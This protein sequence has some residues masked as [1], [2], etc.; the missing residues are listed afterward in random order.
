MIELI[1]GP[2]GNPSS[3][4]QFGR[5]SKTIVEEAR[6]DI[7]KNLGCSGKEI[8]FTSGGTEADNFALNMPI[9]QLGIKRI[10]TSP[11]EHHA[12]LHTAEAVAK[13][14]GVKL[15]LVNLLQNGEVDLS[16]LETLLKDE[17]PTLVSL[18]HGNNEVGN[19]LDIV[20][21]GNLIKKYG[22]LFHSDTVQTVGHFDLKLSEL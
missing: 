18:M 16:H 9:R 3:T 4:H 8:I 22:G 7:A 2:F 19:L 10:I 6:K 21:T 12:V 15:E 17:Q 14:Y 1:N 11:I 20:E 5:K 13:Q